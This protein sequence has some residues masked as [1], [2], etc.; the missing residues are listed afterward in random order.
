MFLL[1]D[2][3]ISTF[4]RPAVA[5]APDFRSQSTSATNQQINSQLATF[6]QE[7]AERELLSNSK[8]SGKKLN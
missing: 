3:N 6:W 7:F 4:L 8:F 2:S 1:L 5:I